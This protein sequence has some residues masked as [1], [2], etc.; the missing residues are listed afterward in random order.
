MF[1]Q[2]GIK[3]RDEMRK[4]LLNARPPPTRKRA[5]ECGYDPEEKSKITDEE[6]SGGSR[7]FF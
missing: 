6:C 1:T 2:E 3:V 4:L 5:C 7:I